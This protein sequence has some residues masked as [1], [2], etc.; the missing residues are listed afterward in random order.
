MMPVFSIAANESNEDVRTQAVPM[1]FRWCQQHHQYH[2]NWPW[3]QPHLNRRQLLPNQIQTI[4]RTK[5]SLKMLT[6][7]EHGVGALL[8]MHCPFNWRWSPCSVP[9]ASLNHTVV[10]GPI[11]LHGVYRLTCV[12]SVDHHR[13]EWN[14][15]SSVSICHETKQN[16]RPNVRQGLTK[17]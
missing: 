14:T 12:T 1:E 8:N 17:C 5:Q 4:Q 3:P 11:V 15:H 7:N 13:S 2:K 16:A 9:H 10:M 6:R